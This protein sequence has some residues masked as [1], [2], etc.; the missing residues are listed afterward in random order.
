MT[1]TT[2]EDLISITKH[3]KQLVEKIY[4]SLTQE[5]LIFIAKHE[6]ALLLGLL[7]RI[8]EDYPKFFEKH[9]SLEVRLRPLSKEEN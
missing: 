9:L 5:D 2:N 4:S 3:K 6:K 7:Q 8:G 1:T